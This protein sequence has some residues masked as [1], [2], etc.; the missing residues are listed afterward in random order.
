MKLTAAICWFDEP[1][2]H[3]DRCVRSLAGIVDNLVAVDGRWAPYPD[4]RDTSPPE[5]ALAIKNAGRAAD[6]ETT[7]RIAG[8]PL[9]WPS[10]ITKRAASLQIATQLGADWILVI[11]ADEHVNTDADTSRIRAQLEQTI[12]DVA[13]ITI[14]NVSGHDQLNV[15]QP[16]RRLFRAGTTVTGWHNGYTL[17]G[18]ALAGDPPLEPALDLRDALR[19]SHHARARSPERNAAATAYRHARARQGER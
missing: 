1:T 3:L 17:N 16:R 18:R 12:R 4:P 9:G 19:I 10:Q 2:E 14:R 7:I 5:Q 6:V 8:A 13:T 11:D 15:D